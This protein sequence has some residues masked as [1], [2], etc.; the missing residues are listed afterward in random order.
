[1][2]NHVCQNHIT[3]Q[4]KPKKNLIYNYCA[5]IPLEIQGINTK[6]PCQKIN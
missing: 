5:I 6:L 3:M 1:M 4:L 2:K